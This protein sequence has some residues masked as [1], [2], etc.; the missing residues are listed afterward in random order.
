MAT[1]RAGM[2]AAPSLRAGRA[3]LT[4]MMAEVVAEGSECEAAGEP[5]DCGA[6]ARN[7]WRRT[8]V[9]LRVVVMMREREVQG[10]LRMD[11]ALSNCPQP[12]PIQSTL[13]LDWRAGSCAAE[14][15]TER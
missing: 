3:A 9:E 5:I 8:A 11:E 12:I 10:T 7:Q 4:S 13:G 14:A 6:W 15:G 1:Y 2:A